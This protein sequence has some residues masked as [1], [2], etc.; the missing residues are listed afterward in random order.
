MPG[1]MM[2][3][4]AGTRWWQETGREG[5]FGQFL[6][7]CIAPDAVNA[8]GFA[9]KEV[10]WHAHLRDEN[11]G[12]WKENARRFYQQQREFPDQDY[13]LGYLIHVM[14]DILW[15]ECFDPVLEQNIRTLTADAQ[16]Q[17]RVRWS[18]LF[19]FDRLASF[20]DWWKEVR[21]AFARAKA[22]PING[23]SETMTELL[24]KD[25]LF[26]YASSIAEQYGTNPPHFVTQED[27]GAL[28]QA[29]V[30]QVQL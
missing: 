3:L 23:I 11:L 22:L 18:E 25:T 7:G 26:W 16:Q 14:T 27:A 4:S 5:N 12:V 6:L 1:Q 2:H 29:L 17:Y 30:K 20:S 21:P 10:R 8:R 24:Q 9:S 19:L 15:D 28:A 13:L